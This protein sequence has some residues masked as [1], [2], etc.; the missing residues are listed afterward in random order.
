[1]HKI[2][3]LHCD[4]LECL[5]KRLASGLREEERGD[6]SDQGTDAEDDGGQDWGGLQQGLNNRFLFGIS[7]QFSFQFTF[8]LGTWR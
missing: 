3:I 2:N 8:S 7:L 1:M 4:L 5:R 6:G